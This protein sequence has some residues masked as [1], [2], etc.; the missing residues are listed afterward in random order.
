MSAEITEVFEKFDDSVPSQSAS[1]V[2]TALPGSTSRECPK[3]FASRI[4]FYKRTGPLTRNQCTNPI[5]PPKRS[6]KKSFLTSWPLGILFE[7]R[8][9][10]FD[11]SGSAWC[12][13][14]KDAVEVE[15]PVLSQ[16][17]Q[18]PLIRRIGFWLG[19]H[20]FTA[21]FRRSVHWWRQ[22]IWEFIIR[23]F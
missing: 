15:I 19:D 6:G 13:K 5:V 14:C 10:Y 7:S 4:R 9:P 22:V 8:G 23:S 1:R 3:C 2:L 20:I 18:F 11:C 17:R 12:P 16:A 21:K